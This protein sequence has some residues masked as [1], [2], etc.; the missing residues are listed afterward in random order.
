M[1]PSY[2]VASLL[3]GIQAANVKQA[4]DKMTPTKPK[5]LTEQYNVHLHLLQD[6]SGFIFIPFFQGFMHCG[7]MQYA[8]SC[9]TSSLTLPDFSISSMRASLLPTILRKSKILRKMD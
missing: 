6:F 7:F 9:C 3:F 2:V 4:S 8:L 5:V 1:D